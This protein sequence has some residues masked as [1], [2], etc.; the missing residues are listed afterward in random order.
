[1]A[2]RYLKTCPHCNKK[3]DVEIENKIH[4]DRHETGPENEDIEMRDDAPHA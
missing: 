3:I 4:F 1:M 2:E